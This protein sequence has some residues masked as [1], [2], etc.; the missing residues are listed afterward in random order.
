MPLEPGT[1]LGSYEILSPIGAGNGIEVY[2][3]TDL[4]AS[5]T[6]AIQVIPP[7][8]A[9]VSEFPARKEQFDRA[10]LAVA[11]LHHPH[12]RAVHDIGQHDGVDFLVLEYLEGQTLAERLNGKPLDLDEAMTVAVAIAD[13]LH[14]AHGAG[15]IHRDLNPSNVLLTK[16]GVKLL[17]FGFAELRPAPASFLPLP[18][19]ASA[20]AVEPARKPEESLGLQYTAPELFEGNPADARADLFA[21]GAIFYEMLTGKKA[22]EGRSRAVL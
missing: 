3:A 13:A 6:V 15:V 5:R 19:S 10:T 16:T 2:K 20:T 11:A 1:K 18:K 9:D 12:I 7:Q 8:W 22:F 4:E 14:K 21:F 17:D